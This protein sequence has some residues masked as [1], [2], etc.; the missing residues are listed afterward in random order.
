[1]ST[2]S[3]NTGVAAWATAMSEQLAV[4]DP[5]L[6]QR[7]ATIITQAVGA[8]D[9]SWPTAAKDWAHTL[10]VYR[11]AKN[12]RLTPEKLV[13]AYRADTLPRLGEHPVV[14]LPQ[15]T[16]ELDY[17]GRQVQGMGPLSYPERQGF[18]AHV[19]LAVTPARVPLGVVAAAFWAR[20]KIYGRRLKAQRKRRPFMGKESARWFAGYAQACAVQA[21]QPATQVVSISD[22]EGDIYECLAAAAGPVAPA[23]GPRAHLLV[24]ACQ[25]LSLIHI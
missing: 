9:R 24:R 13:A 4:T 2:V 12:P 3:P 8:P 14:L 10:G 21:A 23:A 25:D 7:W 5:R 1:M 11:F 20:E 16:T 17:T 22:R 18:L 19:T 15:D 6:P